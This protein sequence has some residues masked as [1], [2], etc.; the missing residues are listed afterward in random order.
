LVVKDRNGKKT[1]KIAKAEERG[2]KIVAWA[3][4]NAKYSNPTA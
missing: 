1:A 2:A 4:F 3:D